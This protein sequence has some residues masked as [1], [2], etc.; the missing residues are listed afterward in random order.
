ME[1]MLLSM[2]SLAAAAEQCDV[3]SFL[4]NPLLYTRMAL[5]VNIYEV[6]QNAMGDIN[7]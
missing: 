3:Y 5:D 7:K 1:L 4:T 6:Q 2:Y